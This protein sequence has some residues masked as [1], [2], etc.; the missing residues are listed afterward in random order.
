MGKE[1][2]PA[3][4]PEIQT[5][6]VNELIKGIIDWHTQNLKLDSGQVR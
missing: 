2:S 1:Q 3:K 6:I 4:A 5:P